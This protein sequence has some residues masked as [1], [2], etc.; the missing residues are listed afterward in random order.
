MAQ[1]FKLL[2]LQPIQ[3]GALLAQGRVQMGSGLIIRV[4]FME[5]KQ[6]QDPFPLP[7]GAKGQG[8]SWT[9]IVEFATPDLLRSWQAAVMLA[10]GKQ[11]SDLLK[12]TPSHQGASNYEAF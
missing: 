3:R 12:Q 1:G 9:Q 10:A 4:N 8:N 2:D 6:G 11:L 5:G 7:A